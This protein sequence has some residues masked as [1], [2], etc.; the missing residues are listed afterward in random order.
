MGFAGDEQVVTPGQQ[1]QDDHNQNGH[2][3]GGSYLADVAG[4][5]EA[6]GDHEKGADHKLQ[7]EAG[8]GLIRGLRRAFLQLEHVRSRHTWASWGLT[9]TFSRWS[10][11]LRVPV[12]IVS[13]GER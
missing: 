1:H 12:S 8:N 6:A 3:P 4:Q 2:G 7:G 5:Q 10:F 9:A 13:A 11:L